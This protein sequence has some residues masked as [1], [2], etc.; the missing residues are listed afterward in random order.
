MIKHRWYGRR[1]IPHAIQNGDRA[2]VEVKHVAW[3]DS[4][5]VAQNTADNNTIT[6]EAPGAGKSNYLV[7][8]IFHHFQAGMPYRVDHALSKDLTEAGN[9]Q[10]E[11]VKEEPDTLINELQNVTGTG[12]DS[13]GMGFGAKG[14]KLPDDNVRYLYAQGS[15]GQE[16]ILHGVDIYYIEDTT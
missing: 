11:A 6:L 7:G 10:T 13:V 16:S 5:A 4:G 1:S 8:A 2:M 3:F 15:A 14:I 9:I 12:C